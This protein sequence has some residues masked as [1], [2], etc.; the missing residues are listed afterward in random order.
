M[1]GKLALALAAAAAMGTAQAD[2]LLI[3]NFDDVDALAPGW[4]LDNRGTQ[5]SVAPGWVQGNPLAFAAHE[6]APDAYIASDFQTAVDN[7]QLDNR[8]FTPLFSLEQGAYASFW[9]RGGDDP[10]YSDMVV[11]GYTEGS[12]DPLEFVMQRDV[13][14][15][16]GEWT[17][18]TLTIGAQAGMGRL[19]F[20]HTGQQATANYVALDTLRVDTLPQG[21]VPEPASMLLLGL[22]M[23]GIAL[24]RRRRS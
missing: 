5:P 11:Y 16:I 2:V 17:R 22:G 20:I 6:G 15:P 14:A 13:T 12:V 18:F 10:G 21:D 23:G 24:A 9:L 19:G 3:E 4:V 7:G 1:I 8:L